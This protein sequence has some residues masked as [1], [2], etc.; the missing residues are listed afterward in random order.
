MLDINSECWLW[1]YFS[2]DLLD[3]E[4]GERSLWF[5]ICMWQGIEVRGRV[6]ADGKQEKEKENK[7]Q[8]NSH[9]NSRA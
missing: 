4:N 7:K 8:W 3:L 2:S 9:F 1:S 6:V 5:G